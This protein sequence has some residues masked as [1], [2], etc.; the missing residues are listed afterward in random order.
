MLLVELLGIGQAVPSSDPVREEAQDLELLFDGQCGC[1]RSLL[2]AT[3]SRNAALFAD[4]RQ[5]LPER[6]VVPVQAG[7]TRELR[8]E[9][10][11]LV[12]IR[13]SIPWDPRLGEKFTKG[14]LYLVRVLRV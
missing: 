3:F 8:L 6:M 5:C 11:E 2:S 14:R 7:V 12:G 1:T 10:A 13:K 4:I 9:F